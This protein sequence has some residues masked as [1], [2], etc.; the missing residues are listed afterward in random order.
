MIQLR[1]WIFLSL[2]ASLFFVS[3]EKETVT[4]S[5]ATSTTET[6][7]ATPTTTAPTS[8]SID[9][10]TS[11]RALAAAAKSSQRNNENPPDSLDNPCGCYDLFNDIDFEA[12]D[13]AIEAAVDAI[14]E[15]LS[16]QE[17]DR[18]FEPVCTEDGEILESA[19]VADCLGITNYHVC[20]DEELEDY[21]F[22]GFE[23]GDLDDLSFPTEIA[24]PDGSTVTVNNEEELFALLEQWY[25]EHGED[26]H[27]DWDEEWEEEDWK[28]CFTVKYPVQV[29][30][31]D[32]T[33]Q[34]FNNEEE[35]Y[36]AIDTWYEANPES[37]ED[38]MPIY[39]IEVE[40]EDGTTQTISTIEEEE[41]L[42]ETCEDYDD[43]EDYFCFELVFPITLTNP[44]NT[45]AVANNEEELD[46]LFETVFE[47]VG[48]EED[49]EEEDLIAMITP[50]DIQ[51]E[52]GT[53]QTIN[54]VD[55]L[56]AAFETCFDGMGLQGKKDAT[57]LLY[58]NKTSKGSF[59][60]KM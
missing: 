23:C 2:V 15:S 38:P 1:R 58:K 47:A 35:L 54:S 12:S 28:E 40:L 22:D 21:F 19:C 11:F 24:L 31:P 10:A 30:F 46:A 42:W 25:E 29:V 3:C 7:N 37:K 55:D 53:I 48:K 14:L 17:I 9:G 51:F 49:I 52:D 4:P 39:P 60:R 33:T 8:T 56:E 45:T 16:D 36:T 26:H 50:L 57:E 13:E 32:G 41:A 6:S 43:Y 44:D 5:A 27:D 20:S 18:L 34:T 59:L